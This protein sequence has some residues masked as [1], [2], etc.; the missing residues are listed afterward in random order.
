MKYYWST[1]IRNWYGDSDGFTPRCWYGTEEEYD[2]ITDKYFKDNS[3]GKI[4][5]ITKFETKQEYLDSLNRVEVSDIDK[6]SQLR[7]EA[8]RYLK[9]GYR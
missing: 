3:L 7:H 8:N 1:T 5:G 6:E 4:I 9:G 2:I